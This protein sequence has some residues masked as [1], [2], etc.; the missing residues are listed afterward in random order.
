[1]AS[2]IPTNLAPF[3]LEE[4]LVATGGTLVRGALSGVLGVSTDTRTIAP[5]NLFVA[6]CGERHDG[7]AHLR[8]AAE[9]GATAAL[10][11]RRM[12]VP[13][14][15]A[16]IEVHDTLE[17]LGALGRAHRRRWGAL[18]PPGR[19]VVGITGSAGKTTTRAVTAA[20]LRAVGLRVHASSGNLNNAIGIPMVLLGL[21]PEHDVAVLEVGT[22]SRG[23][24]AYGCSLIEQ[25]I[26]VITLVAAAHTERIG[27]VAD[28]G[29]EKGAMFASLPR[30]GVAVGNVDNPHVQAHLLRSPA[31]RWFGYGERGGD[32][33]ITLREPEGLGASRVKLAVGERLRAELTLPEEI[34][35][36]LPLLGAAG[37]YA[38]AAATV[39]AAALRPGLDVQAL[40]AGLAQIE[41]EGGRLQA[42]RLPDGTVL[43]DDS[44]NA[45]R[46]SVVASLQA[47]SELARAEGRRL[48]AVLGEMREL[49][50]LAVQEHR[51]VG[52]ACVASGVASLIAVQGQAS[53]IADEAAGGGVESCFSPDASSAIEQVM[54]RLRPGDL[55]L[56]KGS[57]GVGLDRIVRHMTQPSEPLR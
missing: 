37:A 21:G 14:G 20:A 13:D 44:Y 46:A 45:N 3:S 11:Q 8:A 24:I 6:L 23:E 25:D 38:A 51:A 27:T 10:V 26:G 49:G 7:H 40:A 5:G 47:A 30:D 39:I 53:E 12:E 55:V 32:L 33:R 4:L 28:V 56:V 22:S 43:L 54:R 17:A 16:L 15:M 42:L 48:V 31:R 50:D 41:G 57:R 2:P 34:S 18:G 19:R 36:R 52:Q 29:Y 9:A 35:L 1:M